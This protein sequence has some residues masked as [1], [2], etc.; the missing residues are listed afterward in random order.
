VL[1]TKNAKS[2][3]HYILRLGHR[4]ERA[5]KRATDFSA[6]KIARVLFLR[7]QYFTAAIKKKIAAPAEAAMRKPHVL[8]ARAL[9]FQH[10]AAGVYV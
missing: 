4:V 2:G 10:I 5:R 3:A 1:Q 9:P 8:L 6:I 7:R